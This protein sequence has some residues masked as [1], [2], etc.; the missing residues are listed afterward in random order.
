MG[1]KRGRTW[2]EL[3]GLFT[4]I[5]VNASRLRV[6]SLIRFY[7]NARGSY[8]ASYRASY[9]ADQRVTFKAK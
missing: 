6:F 4:S 8:K 1:V 5:M 7:A 2:L 3:G 9:R